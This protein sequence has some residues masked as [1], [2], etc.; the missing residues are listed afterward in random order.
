M[1]DW[2]A[3]KCNLVTITPPKLHPQRCAHLVEDIVYGEMPQVSALTGL[4]AGD[5]A[6][7]QHVQ[8]DEQ[9]QALDL[10]DDP[11]HGGQEV[12]Q[13]EPGDQADSE[14]AAMSQ[15]VHVAPSSLLLSHAERPG[16]RT[17]RVVFM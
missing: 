10:A 8:E 11:D 6:G 14:N 7:R 3:Y 2:Q 4:R 5:N 12:E 17:F 9:A 13:H 15:C 1:L 16:R